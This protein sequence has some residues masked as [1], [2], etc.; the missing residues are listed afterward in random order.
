MK[1]AGGRNADTDLALLASGGAP[2][3]Q[4]SVIDTGKDRAALVE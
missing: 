1:R 4:E 3:Q 2:G